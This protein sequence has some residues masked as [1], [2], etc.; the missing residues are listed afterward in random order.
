MTR[1][2]GSHSLAPLWKHHLA[3]LLEASKRRDVKDC[4]E[5]SGEGKYQSE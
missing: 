5:A 3:E 2:R 1:C 4:L